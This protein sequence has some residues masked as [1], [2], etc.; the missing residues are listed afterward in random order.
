M[1]FQREARLHSGGVEKVQITRIKTNVEQ[2][3]EGIFVNL[4]IRLFIH[5]LC[6]HLF[7]QHVDSLFGFLKMSD[8][9][10]KSVCQYVHWMHGTPVGGHF[11]Y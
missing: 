5:W 9:N 6:Q 4:F 10:N 3:L 7:F 11:A 1:A 8:R 2:T